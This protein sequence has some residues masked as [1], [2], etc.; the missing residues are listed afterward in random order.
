MSHYSRFR[1]KFV[2]RALLVKAL[3]DVGFTSVEQHAEAQPLFGYRGDRRADTAHIIVRRQYVGRMS[4]DIGFVEQPDGSY[5]AI[6]SDFDKRKYDEVWLQ[7]LTQRYAVHAT[8]SSLTEQGYEL[9]Q[10]I[11]D[12]NGSIRLVLNDYSIQ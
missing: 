8:L 10:M 1:T 5:E 4:N 3:A 12:A 6:I 2:D 11:E 7:K 9:A